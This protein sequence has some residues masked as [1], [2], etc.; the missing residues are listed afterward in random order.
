M[1]KN[2]YSQKRKAGK[3]ESEKR[4][5][6]VWGHTAYKILVFDGGSG[7]TPPDP[8]LRIWVGFII[9]FRF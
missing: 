9:S 6:A 4:G 5:F 3:R 1:S 2:Y 7:A 8:N